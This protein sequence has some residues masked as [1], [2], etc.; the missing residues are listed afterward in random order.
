MSSILRKL[1]NDDAGAILAVEWTLLTSVMV[2][3]VT[4]G[5]VMVRDAV[6]A[7]MANV[8][9]TIQTMTPQ[10]T[11]SG[12]RAASASVAGYQSPYVA[13]PVSYQQVAP[14]VTVQ[15]WNLLPPSP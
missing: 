6:N 7:Q 14:N 3:G 4:G 2:M 5:A 8:A 15:Q 11:F 12:W 13:V 9:T 1:W 10:F